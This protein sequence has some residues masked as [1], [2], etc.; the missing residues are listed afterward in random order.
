MREQLER[1]HYYE[2]YSSAATVNLD[3]IE[4]ID[5]PVVE[6]E[7]KTRDTKHMP[8]RQSSTIDYNFTVQETKYLSSVNTCVI[9]NLVGLYGKEL[10][11]NRDKLIKLNKEY[12]R[13][14][15]Q[16]I[17]NDKLDAET[18]INEYN[19]KVRTRKFRYKRKYVFE[20]EELMFNYSLKD[21]F[22]N[23]K[24]ICKITVGLGALS[25]G[26]LLRLAGPYGSIGASTDAALGRPLQ[27]GWPRVKRIAF[28]L[29][30]LLQPPAQPICANWYSAPSPRLPGMNP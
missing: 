30:W 13:V 15:E 21:V 29:G 19:K 27:P 7:M 8:L 22:K 16:P 23:I 17:N 5:D 14:K 2:K 10:K 25:N 12:Q 18:K 4:F 28:T 20:L 24:Q 1:E 26:L 11:M 9:D 6:D 3:D